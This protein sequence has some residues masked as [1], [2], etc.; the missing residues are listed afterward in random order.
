MELQSISPEMVSAQK[1]AITQQ[2]A[3]I[4]VFKMAMDARASQ[5]LQLIQMMSQSTGIGTAVDTR[6]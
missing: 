1:Q 4:R 6:A 5:A 3:G 2:E